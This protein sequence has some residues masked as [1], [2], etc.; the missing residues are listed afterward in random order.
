MWRRSPLCDLFTDWKAESPRCQLLSVKQGG[1]E[2]RLQFP[3]P[4]LWKHMNNRTLYGP[5]D[6]CFVKYRQKTD[7]VL[8]LHISGPA[9][10]SCAMNN[11]N[12]SYRRQCS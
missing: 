9:R 2:P 7:S 1:R 12:S 5:D 4:A 10:E 11:L 6:L 3:C 8:L